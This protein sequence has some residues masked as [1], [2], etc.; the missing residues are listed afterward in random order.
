MITTNGFGQEYDHVMEGRYCFLARN[1]NDLNQQF[2]RS[3]IR[4]LRG[5]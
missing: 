2:N 3:V 1:K 5:C 4:S